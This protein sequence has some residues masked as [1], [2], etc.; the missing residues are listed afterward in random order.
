MACA[1]RSGP[2]TVRSWSV[3][4]LRRRTASGSNSRT[5]R[6]RALDTSVRVREWTTLSVACHCLAHSSTTGGWS[7]TSYAVSQ[8]SI[9]SYIRRP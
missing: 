6:V 8:Y 3:S 1:A 7:G 5:R 9:V 4:A 2:S